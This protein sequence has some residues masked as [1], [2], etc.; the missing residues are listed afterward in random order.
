MRVDEQRLVDGS[1]IKI[2]ERRTA[3][4]GTVGLRTDITAQ[5]ENEIAAESANHAKT[6]FLAHMS[7]ELRTPLN[8]IIGF[9]EV[10]RGKLFGDHAE[11]Y[12]DYAD[13]IH[14]S[15]IMLLALINDILDISKIEANELTPEPALV[16]LP[17][18]VR[19]CMKMVRTRAD[20]NRVT[21]DVELAED[22]STVYAD[23]LHIRQIMLN[24]LSNG[25]K[26][27]PEGGSVRVLTR[28]SENGEVV[29]NVIDDGIGISQ[30]D[31][32]R[33]FEPFAQIGNAMV[34]SQEGSGLGLTLVKSFAE[35]NGGRVELKSAL[36]EGTTISV[37]L[38]AGKSHD[39]RPNEL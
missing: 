14:S 32:F 31:Q 15:G 34:R 30:E 10:I 1:W 35:L 11:S 23:P 13:N 9:S 33:L 2:S 38:P 37:Y 25:V 20:Q 28:R 24:L 6:M 5:K 7:H 3:D 29:V 39:P 17:E 22:A 27:T 4:G 12:T 19:D 18:T 21:L 8:S 36:G 16:D 26:F